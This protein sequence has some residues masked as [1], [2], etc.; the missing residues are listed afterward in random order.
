[1]E[2]DSPTEF[3][4]ES[5]TVNSFIYKITEVRADR[6]ENVIQPL[7]LFYSGGKWGKKHRVVE[8]C[9]AY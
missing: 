4:L 9:T 2:S 1:M 7:P 3:S 8:V 6:F 5:A